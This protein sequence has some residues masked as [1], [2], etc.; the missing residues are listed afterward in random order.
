MKY[1]LSRKTRSPMKLR[2]MGLSGLRLSR[3]KLESG[4]NLIRPV[5][6]HGKIC[7][8]MLSYDTISDHTANCRHTRKPRKLRR[9]IARLCEDYMNINLSY[10]TI[11]WYVFSEVVKSALAKAPKQSMSSPIRSAHGYNNQEHLPSPAPR[12][13]P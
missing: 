8:V 7:Y 1:Y 12:P 3:M 10:R 6:K 4:V 5:L 2:H 9:V 11:Y 13:L